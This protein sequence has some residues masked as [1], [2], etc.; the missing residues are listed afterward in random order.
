[1]LVLADL[2][3]VSLISM[4]TKNNYW[5]SLAFLG[6]CFGGLQEWEG[7]GGSGQFFG[8]IV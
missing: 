5:Y 6:D 1:M 8:S 3:K 4:Q 2:S 7:G